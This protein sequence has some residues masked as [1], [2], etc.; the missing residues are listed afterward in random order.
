MLLVKTRKEGSSTVMVLP[1]N[2]CREL[3][4]EPGDYLTIRP[5]HEGHLV[6][7]PLEE[8]LA[9]AKRVRPRPTR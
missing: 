6:L 7:G 9:H 4:I 2:Y 1:R 3:G 5:D 8:Y